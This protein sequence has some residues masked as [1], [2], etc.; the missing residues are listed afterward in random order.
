MRLEHLLILANISDLG[1]S[2]GHV[3]RGLGGLQHGPEG[4]VV[5]DDVPPPLPVV[6]AEDAGEVVR[7]AG[8][9]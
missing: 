8:P 2:A 1:D 6:L 9:G 4:G 3:L 7:G 5:G